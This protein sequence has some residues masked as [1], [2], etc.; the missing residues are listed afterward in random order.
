VA[1]DFDDEAGCCA[2]DE[3]ATTRQMLT[4]QAQSGFVIS[5]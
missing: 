2:D 4:M 3:H 1:A 5:L